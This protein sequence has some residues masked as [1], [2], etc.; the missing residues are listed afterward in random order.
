MM[1][2]NNQSK[3]TTAI[4]VPNKEALARWAKSRNIDLND[5]KGQESVLLEIE[6]VIDQYKEGGACDD[7]FPSRWLPSSIAI[8]SESFTVDNTLLNSTGKMV[9]GK[10]VDHFRDRIDYLYTPEGKNIINQENI[11]AIRKILNL[12]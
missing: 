6:S 3:F 8:V 11:K 10:I 5:T 12:G 1:L 9:R 2:Y 7:L 4:I